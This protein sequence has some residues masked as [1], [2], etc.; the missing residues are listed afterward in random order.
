MSKGKFRLAK[1][2]KQLKLI[3]G[4]TK[5]KSKS[6]NNNTRSETSSVFGSL[7]AAE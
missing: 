3:V 7:E 6:D 4:E 2:K 1:A 5:A